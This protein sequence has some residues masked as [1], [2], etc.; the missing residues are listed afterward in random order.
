MRRWRPPALVARERGP[1]R[2]LARLLGLLLLLVG[3]PLLA[4]PYIGLWRL[5]EAARQGSAAALAP[6]VDLDSV[7]GE[8]LRRLN[9]D[10]DSDIKKVSDPFIQWIERGLREPGN[11]RLQRS[12]T[13]EWIDELLAKRTSGGGFLADVDYAFYDPPDGFLVRIASPD[14]PLLYLRLRLTADGWRI[15]AVYY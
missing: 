11:E 7:R 15:G 13:V 4:W 8:I 3:V 10:S 12:V 14:Q 6:W 2:A 1:A 5:N 9:K